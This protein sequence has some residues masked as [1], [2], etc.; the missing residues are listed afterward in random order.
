MIHKPQSLLRSAR[1]ITTTPR[2]CTGPTTFPWCPT[3]RRVFWITRWRSPV[4]RWRTRSTSRRRLATTVWRGLRW[5]W[6]G[7]KSSVWWESLLVFYQSQEGCSLHDYL[8]LTELAF[9]RR[10][11]GFISHSLRWHSGN[12]QI[13]QTMYFYCG[14]IFFRDGWRY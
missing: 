5:F 6:T 2:W 1:S 10:Q 4:S 9:C 13:W 7:L 8:L 12:F 3:P 11:L 14:L